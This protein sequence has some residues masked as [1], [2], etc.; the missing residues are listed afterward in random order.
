MK[1][2]FKIM[3]PVFLAVLFVVGCSQN[4]ELTDNEMILN[5][6]NEKDITGIDSLSHNGI[7][8]VDAACDVGK[9]SSVASYSEKVYISYYDSTNRN[10]KLASSFDRGVNWTVKTIDSAGDV[11]KFCSISVSAN[12][13]YIMYV[14]STGN[15]LKLAKSSDNGNTW[16]FVSIH[17]AS[18]SVSGPSFVVMGASIYAAYYRRIYIDSMIYQVC[19][20]VSKDWGKTWSFR[21]IASAS[22]INQYGEDEDCM[23]C[24][25]YSN[26]RLYA[27][28]VDSVT[29][30][31]KFY[32]SSDDGNS[33]SGSDVQNAD[34]MKQAT[35]YVE[36]GNIT[37]P[38]NPSKSME[39]YNSYDNGATWSYAGSIGAIPTY[40]SMKGYGNI[41]YLSYCCG[42]RLFFARST[43][44]G[45]SW[46]NNNLDS[47]EGKN[48]G[49]Y[50]SLSKSDLNND[51]YISYYDYKGKKLKFIR[52]ID[53]GISWGGF[54]IVSN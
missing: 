30:K 26:Y 10:L 21:N 8:T 36:N 23:T 32:T 19:F 2:T 31:M 29:D 18:Y 7:I 5:S 46:K 48:T 47:G 37:L 3:V 13:I 50:T 16:S 45:Q 12:T 54:S 33:W 14:D 35:M 51:I 15:R 52:S 27:G 1:R 53:G 38:C 44:F 49:W 6:Q 11:G 42:G 43:D 41:L 20:A 28:F 40:P 17:D 4:E 34:L 24:I 22:Y 39:C 25:K 9:Y